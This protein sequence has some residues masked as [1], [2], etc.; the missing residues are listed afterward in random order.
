[1]PGMQRDRL[2]GQKT[3]GVGPADHREAAG[4][5]EVGGDLGEKLV[6]AE[7]DRHGDADL[8]LDSPRKPRQHL[9]G[10]RSVQRGGAGEVEKCLVDRQRFDQWRQRVHH[11]APWRETPTYFCMSGLMIT[12]SGQS[13]LA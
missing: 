1:M 12:A 10:A 13:F 6:V 11:G 2:V 8:V 9:G 5:V 7:A 3:D 4:L